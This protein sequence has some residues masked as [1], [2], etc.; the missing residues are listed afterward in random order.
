[1]AHSSLNVVVTRSSTNESV[2][3]QKFLP[4]QYALYRSLLIKDRAQLFNQLT[5]FYFF[6]YL[7][8]MA[9]GN[10]AMAMEIASGPVTKAGPS[11]A[12]QSQSITLKGSV[13]TVTEY[14]GITK[15]IQS[16]ARR[17]AV[18]LTPS[19]LLLPPM[20]PKTGMAIN[21]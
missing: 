12:T 13:A 5:L 9:T 6:T 21:R 14:F 4:R 11:T 3:T 15:N 7:F 2:R 17:L 20:T 1:M 16:L 8:T 19:L 18:F 10:V